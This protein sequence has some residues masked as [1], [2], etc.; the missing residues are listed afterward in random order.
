MSCIPYVYYSFI[1]T[2]YAQGTKTLLFSLESSRSSAYFFEV[3]TP[4][5]K[6]SRYPCT[7]IRCFRWYFCVLY[8]S[9]HIKLY[10][11]LITATSLSPILSIKRVTT[12]SSSSH[13]NYSS[14]NSAP[15]SGQGPKSQKARSHRRARHALPPLRQRRS[16]IDRLWWSP[17]ASVSLV[18]FSINSARYIFMYL[19][20]EN[21]GWTTQEIQET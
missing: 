18:F 16:P 9:N 20:F 1:C 14:S 17:G 19:E 2:G 11:T 12:L 4:I 8:K 3:F 5:P 6:V 15:Y 10:R 13:V 7:F 21:C